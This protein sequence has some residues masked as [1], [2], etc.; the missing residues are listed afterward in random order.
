MA[1]RGVVKAWTE[2]KGFGFL[3]TAAGEDVFVHRTHLVGVRGRSSGDARCASGCLRQFVV[4]LG[5]FEGV[6]GVFHGVFKEF[7][8][9][10]RV[11]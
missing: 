7:V 1:V 11:F 3:T 5:M 6:G 2:E 9:Y 4:Y 8:V 10:L